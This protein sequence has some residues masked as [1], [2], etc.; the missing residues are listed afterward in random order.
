VYLKDYKEKIKKL[1]DSSLAAI[2]NLLNK[3]WYLYGINTKMSNN[4]FRYN[5]A[6]QVPDSI[7]SYETFDLILSS[8][9]DPA[10]L[11][12]NKPKDIK[13]DSIWLVKKISPEAGTSITLKDIESGYGNYTKWTG[14]DIA[15]KAVTAVSE[16][17][18][19]DE[20]GKAS[21]WT[22]NKV[23]DYKPSNL[24]ISI[25]PDLISTKSNEVDYVMGDP[26]GKILGVYLNVKGTLR[27]KESKRNAFYDE[28]FDL[29]TKI[30]YPILLY[31]GENLYD[32]KYQ[33]DN[34]SL[35]QKL[36]ET[37]I[38][39]NFIILFDFARKVE[40][41]WFTKEKSIYVQGD[42][43]KTN[44]IVDEDED[45]N[46][47]SFT[48]FGVNNPYTNNDFITKN[49]AKLQ[50]IFYVN[51][52]KQFMEEKEKEERTSKE[53]QPYYEKYGKKY[54]D[55]ALGGEVIVGMHED[56]LEIALKAWV[57]DDRDDFKN[58]YTLR[59]HYII[60]TDNKIKIFVSK[61]SNKVTS[62]NYYEY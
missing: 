35:Y 12:E 53:L 9:S 20:W 6:D 13:I 14:T 17:N 28:T 41:S 4:S 42:D 16:L 37:D 21:F 18:F 46:P 61:D 62:V 5:A 50:T 19:N 32:A 40:N 24:K 22:N 60:S 38:K 52:Y 11:I 58:F 51:L 45:L 25:E 47:F 23:S 29:D 39:E 2:Q 34:G 56:L 48:T 3:D 33:K 30:Y 27:Y 26:Y 1:N 57:L 36:E 8:Y 59:L 49:M 10:K 31:R 15:R 44:L 55:S 43:D 7:L 54:V